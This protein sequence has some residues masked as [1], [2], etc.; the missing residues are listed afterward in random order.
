VDFTGQILTRPGTP[1]RVR[2][3]ALAY[4]RRTRRLTSQ[5]GRRRLGKNLEDVVHA[6]EVPQVMRGSAVPVNRDGILRCRP[7]LLGLAAELEGDYPVTRRGLVMLQELLRDGASPI[8]AGSTQGALEQ[9]L[10][11]VRAALLL[12]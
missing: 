3:R 9:A 7:L 2:L 4:R 8:Y 10:N 11:H 5:R 12:Q 1:L 6:A